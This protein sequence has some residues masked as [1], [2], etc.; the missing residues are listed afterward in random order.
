MAEYRL[1]VDAPDLLP[2]LT[3]TCV[4]TKLLSKEEWEKAESL[5][6]IPVYLL[7]AKENAVTELSPGELAD[8]LDALLK[9]NDCDVIFLDNMSAI[10]RVRRLSGHGQPGTSSRP[11][12]IRPPPFFSRPVNR[13]KEV[14]PQ[15]DRGD[16][17]TGLSTGVTV[18][19]GVI[20]VGVALALVGMAA[21]TSSVETGDGNM[22]G[23]GTSAQ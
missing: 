13:S 14:I 11:R 12:I 17:E 19:L 5:G 7:Y 16:E 22:A 23:R 6:D 15:R 3:T 18:A 10:A 2:H 9:P 4:G 8:V 1:V 21:N 20:G